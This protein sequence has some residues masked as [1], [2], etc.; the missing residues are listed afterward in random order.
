MKPIIWTRRELQYIVNA[1]K[2]DPE[3]GGSLL[4]AAFLRFQEGLIKFDYWGKGILD[5]WDEYEK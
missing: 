4:E 2:I 3:Y 5:K 1:I